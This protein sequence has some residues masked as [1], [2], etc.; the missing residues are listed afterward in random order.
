MCML[1]MALG[2]YVLLKNNKKYST[3]VSEDVN[4]RLCCPNYF[5]VRYTYL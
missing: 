1:R 5:S 4:V 2:E 3:D